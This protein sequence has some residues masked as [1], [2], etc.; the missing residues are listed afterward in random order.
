MTERREAQEPEKESR[1]ESE[2][3]LQWS[4]DWE[5]CER[6]AAA[7]ELQRCLGEPQSGD[8]KVA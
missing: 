4:Y 2:E 8:G 1:Y 6:E 5:R 3:F 7:E